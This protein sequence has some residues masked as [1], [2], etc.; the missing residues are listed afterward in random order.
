MSMV[1]DEFIPH[2]LSFQL[3]RLLLKTFR[4]EVTKYN[5]DLRRLD[6][7]RDNGSA[8]SASPGSPNGGGRCVSHRHLSLEMFG[9]VTAPKAWSDTCAC[10]ARTDRYCFRDSP[11]RAQE[12]PPSTGENSVLLFIPE[13]PDVKY[14]LFRLDMSPAASGRYHGARQGSRCK[15][16]PDPF[17]ISLPPSV[18]TCR[19]AEDNI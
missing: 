6:N 2:F 17:S 5:S 14:H 8:R 3:P 4:V 15:T 1:G 12:Q 7:A 18:K 19:S 9:R 13:S 16:R 11:P 10:A